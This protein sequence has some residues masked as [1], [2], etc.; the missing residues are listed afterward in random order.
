[1]TMAK[2]MRRFP[3]VFVVAMVVSV[4]TS[5]AT[6]TQD[7]RCHDE[8]TRLTSIDREDLVSNSDLP[9]GT[10]RL[11]PRLQGVAGKAHRATGLRYAVMGD[12]AP[13]LQV[14]P[15]RQISIHAYHRVWI[16]DAKVLTQASPRGP[17]SA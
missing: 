13:T 8:T 11:R 1:M 5:A 17:P 2:P 3:A 15:P 4:M 9:A 14:P 6:P 16:D 7:C 12:H 10:L